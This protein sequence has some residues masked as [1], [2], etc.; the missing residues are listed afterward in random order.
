MPRTRRAGRP[1]AGRGARNE[2]GE[3]ERAA[4]DRAL[5]EL[6]GAGVVGA[7]IA[8]AGVAG[9]G[10]AGA[11]A[12]GSVDAA[13]GGDVAGVPGAKARGRARRRDLVLPLLQA[14]QAAAGW[15]SPGAIDYIAARLGVPATDV[16]GVATFY[17]MLSTRPQGRLVI[18]VC[19]DVSCWMAGAAAVLDAMAAELGVAPGESTPDLAVKLEAVPCLGGCDRAPYALVGGEPRGCLTAAAAREVARRCRD[20]G[21]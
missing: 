12:A 20:G 3:I 14:A 4:I 17:S 16:Y 9:T 15:C 8:G 1:E 5:M 2:A 11:G 10:V 6:A 7:G 18:R 13:S 19:D 21:A